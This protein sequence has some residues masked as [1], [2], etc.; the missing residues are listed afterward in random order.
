MNVDMKR[1]GPQTELNIG[2]M[3]VKT[4]E[5]TTEEPVEGRA[6]EDQVV[7]WN[8]GEIWIRNWLL[9]NPAYNLEAEN[10]QKFAYDFIVYLTDG[11]FTVPH[12]FDAGQYF[13]PKAKYGGFDASLKGHEM[14]RYG[15]VGR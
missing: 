10:C 9:E 2:Y 4:P 6:E 1:Y 5:Q 3:K 13:S 7:P 15:Y 14:K 8:D 11:V 12:R